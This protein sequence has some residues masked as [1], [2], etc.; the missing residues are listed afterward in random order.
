MGKAFIVM[1]Y[2]L[3]YNELY[4]EVIKPVC[5][6]H[7]FEPIREDES[8]STGFIL[9][10]IFKQINEAKFIIAEITPSNPNVYFEI[11]YAV[12]INKPIIFVADKDNEKSL[13]FDISGFRVLF[14]QNTISGKKK[15]EE[16]LSKHIEAILSE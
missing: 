16:G 9:S 15:I 10:D 12:A 8:S 1:E 13:P 4:E 5:I 3:P 2:S 14:Y 7:K 6:N 11:G